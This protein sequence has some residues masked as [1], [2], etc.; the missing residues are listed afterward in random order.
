MSQEEKA[1]QPKQTEGVLDKFEPGGPLGPM[2]DRHEYEK[3]L[4]SLPD[5]EKELAEESTRLADIC[6]Y[7]SRQKMD[8]PAQ[9]LEQIGRL[10]A[11]TIA[12]RV[13]MLKEINRGLM[14]FL[15]DVDQGPGIRH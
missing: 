9:F 14:E 10:A 1:N 2:E 11:L 7:F 5:A 15:N 3:R 13:C 8:I 4:N 12:A 6:Q